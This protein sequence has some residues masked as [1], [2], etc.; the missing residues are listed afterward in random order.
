VSLIERLASPV[1]VSITNKSKMDV[2]V[3]TLTTDEQEAIRAAAGNP[4]WGNSP[5]LNELREAGAPDI[6][7]SAFREWRKKQARA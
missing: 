6:S 7:K 4:A 1:S 5:L 2:W 3:E